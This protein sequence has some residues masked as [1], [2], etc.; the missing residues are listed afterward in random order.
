MTSIVSVEQEL[1][2]R[3]RELRQE[4]PSI[5]KCWV[6]SDDDDVAVW[7]VVTDLDTRVDAAILSCF[8][9]LFEFVGERDLDLNLLHRQLGCPKCPPG[10]RELE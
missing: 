8:A 7:L 3:I 4:F 6:R 10:F 5:D 9:E 1:E 2:D